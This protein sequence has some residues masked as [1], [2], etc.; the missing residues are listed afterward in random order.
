M[1]HRLAYLHAG[2]HFLSRF[3]K[4]RTCQ[5]ARRVVKYPWREGNGS[6]SYI[7]GGDNVTILEVLAL[8]NLIAVV[9]FGILNVTTKK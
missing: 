4:G 1:M 2:V 3:Q 9:V 6:A 5:T 8:L 7:R